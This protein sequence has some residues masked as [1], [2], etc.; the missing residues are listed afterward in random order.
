MTCRANF[1]KVF[2]FLFFIKISVR[3]ERE[4]HISIY[5]IDWNWPASEVM[6]IAVPSYG[7]GVV[8][9]GRQRAKQNQRGLSG[10]TINL[11]SCDCSCGPANTGHQELWR[12][13][14]LDALSRVLC[15]R[16]NLCT[17]GFLTREKFNK[18]GEGLALASSSVY[19]NKVNKLF[20]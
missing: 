19:R 16:A 18:H 11:A 12:D 14:H 2:E 10:N 4:S 17:A 13:I 3:E 20:T 15:K 9:T 1:K 5:C 8:P 7:G 6:K